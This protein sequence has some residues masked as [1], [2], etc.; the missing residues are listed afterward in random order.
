[1]TGTPAQKNSASAGDDAAKVAKLIGWIGRALNSKDQA[2][3]AKIF[4]SQLPLVE[5]GPAGSPAC[6]GWH[7]EKVQGNLS[8]T[9]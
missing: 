8:L 4:E 1:M 9:G 6:F 5:Q 2:D 3:H 7:V